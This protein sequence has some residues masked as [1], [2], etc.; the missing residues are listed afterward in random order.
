M[1][2]DMK[3]ISKKQLRTVTILVRYFIKATGAIVLYVRNDKGTCYYVRL[4]ENGVHSCNCP[5]TKRCY[6]IDCCEKVESARKAKW[7]AYKT[8]LAKQLARQ[9]VSTS[10]V[11]E[12]AMMAAALTTNQGYRLLR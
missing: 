4:Q 7:D 2:K 11:T 9:Y 3:T 5:A 8:T 6:H 10:V 1:T 12:Q